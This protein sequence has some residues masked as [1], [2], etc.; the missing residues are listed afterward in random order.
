MQYPY[1]EKRRIHESPE[2]MARN[3]CTVKEVVK[4]VMVQHLVQTA[5]GMAYFGDEQSVYLNEV[6]NVDH[7]GRMAS[8]APKVA[9]GVL[10]L[11]GPRTGEQVLRSYG[12]GL[13]QWVY[14][15]GVPAGQL[16]LAL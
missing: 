4:A 9:K 6:K 15:W 12:Q 5:L 14:W 10:L 1:F 7:L 8:L 13:V 11:L 2:V 3:K 16:L